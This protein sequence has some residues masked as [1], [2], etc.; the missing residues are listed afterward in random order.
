MQGK[1]IKIPETLG[2][3]NLVLLA[4]GGLV[5]SNW[6]MGWGHRNKRSLDTVNRY[7]RGEAK[8]ISLA[9]CLVKEILAD[10]Q[11]AKYLLAPVGETETV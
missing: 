10:F 5:H 4:L 11:E 2:E 1:D 8:Q 7:L 3:L 6:R 9:Q